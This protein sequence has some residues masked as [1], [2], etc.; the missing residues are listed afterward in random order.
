MN[1]NWTIEKG[2]LKDL[3]PYDKNPEIFANTQEEHF[4]TI[5]KKEGSYVFRSVPIY[6]KNP[7]IFA[8]TQEEHF[9]T[10]VKKE[11]SYVFRSVPIKVVTTQE[12]A[13][14]IILVTYICV[15]GGIFK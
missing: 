10:I 7:E 9:Y 5:L 12:N 3:K 2:L 15:C 4:Y 11:G 6:D 13:G 14:H 8:N 1:I